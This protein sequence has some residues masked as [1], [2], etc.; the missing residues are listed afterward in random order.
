MTQQSTDIRE[1]IAMASV[2]SDPFTDLPQREWRDVFFGL[3]D[4]VQ[5]FLVADLSRSELERFI[6]RLDPDE[7]SE[8]LR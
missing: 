2:P 5:E 8:V 1:A 7:V 3:S 6:D 4:E